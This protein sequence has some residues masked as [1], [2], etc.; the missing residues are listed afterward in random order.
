MIRLLA[1][2]L[3]TSPV[4][5][6]SLSFCVSPVERDNYLMGEGGKGRGVEPNHTMA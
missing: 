1:H 2:P 6:Y 3:P 5:K 4:S